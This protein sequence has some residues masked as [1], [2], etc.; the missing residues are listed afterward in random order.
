MWFSTG[1]PFSS[2]DN[3]SHISNRASTKWIHTLPCKKVYTSS[4]SN[5][6][7]AMVFNKHIVKNPKEKR[8]LMLLGARK[9]YICL[10]THAFSDTRC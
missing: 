3:T 8:L 5:L 6:S 7:N 4:H 2:F 10:C 1:K 9:H